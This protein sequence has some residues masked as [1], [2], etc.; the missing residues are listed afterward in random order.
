MIREQYDDVYYDWVENHVFLDFLDHEDEEC[1]AN[2]Q[3]G[4]L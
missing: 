2:P 4:S 1:F 3:E